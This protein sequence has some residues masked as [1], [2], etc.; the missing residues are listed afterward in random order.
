MTLSAFLACVVCKATHSL[1][2]LLNKGGTALPGKLALKICPDILSILSKKVKTIAVT[3]TNGKTTSAR[4]LENALKKAGFAVFS[5][6]SGANLISGIA[7][8]FILNAN[9]FGRPKCEWAVIEC[10]EAA[11]RR[12]FA[13][14][15][16]AAV[17]VTNL[18]R[19]QLDRYGT[20]KTP[21]DSIA[22]GIMKS[23]D[24][25]LCL[26]ADCPMA[27]SIGERV[28]NRKLYFGLSS[29]RRSSPESGESDICPMCG[30]K[31]RYAYVTYAN[32]GAFSCRACGFERKNTDVTVRELLDDGFILSEGN[33]TFLGSSA[34]PGLYNV[35]NAAGAVTALTAAG[36]DT[37]EALGSIADFDCGF[38]RMERFEIGENGARMILIKNAAAADQTLGYIKSV[39]GPKS[40]AFV[41]N[42]R[43]ADGTD[44]S[45]LDDADLGRISGMRELKNVYVCG[46]R[47]EE[48][49]NR[50][51]KAGIT[52][53]MCTSYDKLISYMDME[54]YEV[55][56]MPTYTAMMELRHLLVRHIGGRE[57]WEQ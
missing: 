39:R 55:F 36:L 33:K 13:E 34:L 18:F 41:I 12:V 56:V 37:E 5:N 38:G 30:A 49:K 48:I 32:L 17:L 46:E 16:P 26:N 14:I 57:F 4:M 25:V 11:S 28:P 24:T 27:A 53:F 40:L 43:I 10:D 31:M 23:P 21:R 45:W 15:K 47:A 6:R 44:I 20:V 50:L 42:S 7:A 54:K 22:D 35:Y 52:C 1:L 51:E 3:G 2:R 29:G 9:I 8:E 19:D